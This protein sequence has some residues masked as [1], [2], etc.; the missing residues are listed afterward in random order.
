MTQS[1]RFQVQL[2][3]FQLLLIGLLQGDMPV[4]YELLNMLFDDV[5]HSSVALR[6]A[7]QMTWSQYRARLTKMFKLAEVSTHS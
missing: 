3:R 1:V 2:L 5:A 4:S 6:N 7:V